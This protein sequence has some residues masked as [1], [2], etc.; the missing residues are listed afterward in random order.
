VGFNACELGVHMTNIDID[1]KAPI[2]NP[3]PPTVNGKSTNGSGAHSD[4]AK[5]TAT[6]VASFKIADVDGA[7]RLIEDI[8]FKRTTYVIYCTVSSTGKQVLVQYADDPDIATTQIAALA[9]LI[10]LRNRLQSLL[11]DIPKPDQYYAQIAEAFRL[12]LEG[13]LDISKQTLTDAV[14]E[15]QNLRAS[16]GRNIYINQAGPIAATVAAALL[17]VSAIFLFFG[18][19][20]FAKAWSPLAHL[21]I[22]AGAGALGA[23]LSIA[24]S[25]RTRTVATDG[26]DLSIRIDA[27]LRVLIGVLSAA[28]LYLILGTGV[29]SQ[30]KIGDMT[31]N[32]GAIVWQLALLLG[33]AAGFLERLVPDL[34]EKKTT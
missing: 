10:P 24:I 5:P 32:P 20:Q 19:A 9:E 27:A 21:L 6:T 26:D 1:P 18:N 16:A 14:T 23:L 13:K 8:Y 29:M 2:E 22:A 17:L 31:F 7:G 3:S 34:L 30:I 12:G 28:V 33:F 15:V 11:A 25:V 4:E